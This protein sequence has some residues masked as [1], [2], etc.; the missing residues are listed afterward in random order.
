MESGRTEG[1]PGYLVAYGCYCDSGSNAVAL[2]WSRN[3]L[4]SRKA[5]TRD[6]QHNDIKILEAIGKVVLCLG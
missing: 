6:M 1:N 2:H 5:G 4:L 3:L